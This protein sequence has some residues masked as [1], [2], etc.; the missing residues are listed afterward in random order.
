[1]SFNVVEFKITYSC[2]FKCMFCI[3]GDRRNDRRRLVPIEMIEYLDEIMLENQI[4]TIHI[5]GG[6]PTLYK[7]LFE[8]LKEIK[9]RPIKN[10]I[11]HTN[12]VMLADIEY[13]KDIL[14]IVTHVFISLHTLNEY[15]HKSI[16]GVDNMLKLQL[17]GIENCVSLGSFTLIN[18]VITKDNLNELID[19]SCYL[20]NICV[21]GWMIT[22]PFLAGWV[23]NNKDK[24]IVNSLSELKVQLYPAIEKSINNK[25]NVVTN[26]LPLC[27]LDNHISNLI[28]SY[29]SIIKMGFDWDNRKLIDSVSVKGKEENMLEDFSNIYKS[30]KCKR[31][32][33]NYDCPGFSKELIDTGNWPQLQIVK[34]LI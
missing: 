24:I 29:R 12:A 2:N 20:S 19:I 6:E 10:I 25:M 14:S 8:L 18:T 3:V 1:M 31:C 28:D 13:A 22:F 30:K 32:I 9:K 21:S 16:S 15:T 5:S 34:T 11:L 17:K 27:Y 23:E 7:E 26:G 33:L 4:N